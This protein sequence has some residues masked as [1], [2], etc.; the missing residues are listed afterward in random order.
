MVR[1]RWENAV[2]DIGAAFDHGPDLLAVDG[3]GDDGRAVADE[4]GDALYRHSRIRQ[5]R[6]EAVP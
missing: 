5:Q 4:P 6:H 1:P 3:F 2:H